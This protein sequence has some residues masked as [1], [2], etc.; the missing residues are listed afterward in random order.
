MKVILI[1]ALLAAHLVFTQARKQKIKKQL[2]EVEKSLNENK[3]LIENVHQD[4]GKII[5][6]VKTE[7]NVTNEKLGSLMQKV[8]QSIH[9]NERH[10]LA[11]NIHK[12]MNSS[13]KILDKVRENC[14]NNRNDTNENVLDKIEK[15]E[16]DMKHNFNK[17]MTVVM[18]NCFNNRNDTKETIVELIKEVNEMKEAQSDIKI[19]LEETMTAVNETK[20]AQ[21]DIKINL[22]ET[23]MAVNE[24]KEA[25]SG[26]KIN[27]EET[28]RAVNET[29]EA[30]ID[31][32]INLEET[33]TA[34][35]EMKEAQSDIKNNLEETMK[36]VTET[37]KLLQTHMDIKN[38]TTFVT[39]TN[40]QQTTQDIKKQSSYV[41]RLPNAPTTSWN[42]WTVRRGQVDA[43]DFVPNQSISILGITL[44][45]STRSSKNHTG[46]IQVLD[47]AT[48]KVIEEKEFSFTADGSNSYYDQYF[49]TP[50][51][52]RAGEKYTVTVEYYTSYSIYYANGGMATTT[53]TCNGLDVTFVFS[54]SADSNNGSRVN[55]GQIPRII[56]KC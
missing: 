54:N 16:I 40:P 7:T 10:A 49:V 19:N 36:A 8:N 50:A 25:Q 2:K 47:Q 13:N 14:I 4:T 12:I 42:M 52:V 31:I 55:R 24:M 26:I 56:F 45:G 35:N 46:K 5:N 33:M 32:K 30:Q 17:A 44:L 3:N 28:M 27:L 29:K 23:M 51:V 21:S 20:E 6:L 22:E 9:S 39:P 53:A 34:V 18:E 15:V 41:L 1:G 37:L 38:F 48:K 43:I 11:E